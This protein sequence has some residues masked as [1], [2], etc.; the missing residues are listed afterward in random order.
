MRKHI[1]F[2]ETKDKLPYFVWNKLNLP[3]T[4]EQPS[5]NQDLKLL[6]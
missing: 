1:N 5:F 3:N 6:S 4:E 2:E